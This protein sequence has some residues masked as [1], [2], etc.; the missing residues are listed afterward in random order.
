MKSKVLF[1]CLLCLLA[2]VKAEVISATQP[3]PEVISNMLQA[4][5]GLEVW[6]SAAG[7]RML[8]IAH[9]ANL[10]LPLVREFWVDFKQPRIR[11]ETRGVKQAQTN[12]LNLSSGWTNNAG[13][14]KDWESSQVNGWRSFWPGIPTRIFHLLA[15]NDK[16]LTYEIKKDRTDFYV[17]GVFAV[18]IATDADGTPVAYGRN[19]NHKDTHFLGEVMPYGSVKLWNEAIEPGGQWRVVMVDY[20]LLSQMP[21]VYI[22]P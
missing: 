18:W 7:F 15:S 19:D 12:V 17:D 16:S 3:K 4:V 6:Q 2:P 11:Q 21:Q 20:E 10:K 1:W 13:Q 14:I 9:Y 22:K 8:E 5:G